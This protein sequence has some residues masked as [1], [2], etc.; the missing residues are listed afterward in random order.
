MPHRNKTIYHNYINTL[1]Q[2]KPY[3]FHADKKTQCPNQEFRITFS[4]FPLPKTYVSA[5]GTVSF[6]IGKPTVPPCET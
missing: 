2:N 6:R 4:M 3:L 1:L 5:S